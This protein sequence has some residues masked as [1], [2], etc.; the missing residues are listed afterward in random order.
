M[1]CG[2]AHQNTLIIH[3]ARF[4]NCDEYCKKGKIFQ[5][6]NLWKF[7]F[8]HRPNV[9]VCFDD[10]YCGKINLEP[11]SEKV[12]IADRCVTRDCTQLAPTFIYLFIYYLMQSY[13]IPFTYFVIVKKKLPGFI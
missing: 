9:Q 4:S 6:R 2:V 11:V 5:P 3:I 7:P 1:L 8:M 10:R 12:T 13:L